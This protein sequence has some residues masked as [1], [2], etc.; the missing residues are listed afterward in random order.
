MCLNGTSEIS[1]VTRDLA[2][3]QPEG[4]QFPKDGK[5]ERRVI[6]PPILAQATRYIP[7]HC[8]IMADEKT[9]FL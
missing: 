5:E 3:S 7:P 1:V 6:K 4:R 2:E 9:F 8:P